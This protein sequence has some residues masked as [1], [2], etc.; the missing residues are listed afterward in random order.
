MNEDQF[1]K[2]R[3]LTDNGTFRSQNVGRASPVPFLYIRFANRKAIKE[4]KEEIGGGKIKK[5]GAHFFLLV[6]PAL[7]RKFLPKIVPD[8]RKNYEAAKIVIIWLDALEA[9]GDG[10]S[11]IEVEN[12]RKLI[13]ALKEQLSALHNEKKEIISTPINR[14]IG[15]LRHQLSLYEKTP[16]TKR[17]IFQKTKINDLMKK[18]AELAPEGKEAQLLTARKECDF[19]E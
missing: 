8:L 14:D 9:N 2:F 6:G 12:N 7:L 13:L 5:M 10:L 4:Y 15:I 18:L 16:E 11:Q 3:R 17:T 1:E 19:N